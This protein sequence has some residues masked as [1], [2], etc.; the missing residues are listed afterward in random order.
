[1]RHQLPIPTP[2]VQGPGWG[3]IGASAES[4]V[5]LT[6]TL[7]KIIK[8]LKI[9]EAK[10]DRFAVPTNISYGIFMKIK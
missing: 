3:S 4:V 5:T 2:S 6:S 10:D 1:L 8:A 9:A 7:Q